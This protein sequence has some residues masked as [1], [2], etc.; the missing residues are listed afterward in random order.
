MRVIDR[1]DDRKTRLRAGEQRRVARG[2]L[3]FD[4]QRA[5]RLDDAA[6]RRR[7]V[8]RNRRR[9]DAPFGA[10]EA[11]ETPGLRVQAAAGDARNH[12]RQFLVIDRFGHDFVDA[13]AHGIEQQRGFELGRENHDRH[14]GVLPLERRDH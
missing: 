3:Q 4:H 8:D 2:V 12:A 13:G 5:F 10:D 6:E 7:D 11:V 14:V 9:A 1:V